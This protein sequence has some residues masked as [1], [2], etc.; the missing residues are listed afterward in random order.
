MWTVFTLVLHSLKR[1]IDFSDIFYHFVQNF[2]VIPWG[3]PVFTGFA[4][5]FPA[6]LVFASRYYIFMK[7]KEE[8]TEISR[9]L[10]ARGPFGAKSQ[11]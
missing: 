2:A 8:F 3:V 6:V 9:S 4:P 5:R 11:I 10:S 1:K 7:I